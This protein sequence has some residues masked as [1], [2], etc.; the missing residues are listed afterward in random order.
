MSCWRGLLPGVI[1]TLRYV[2]E[3]PLKPSEQTI[4]L[5]HGL[6]NKPFVMNGI[7]KCFGKRGIRL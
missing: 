6:L 4:V 1:W 7:A 2:S 3:R 5:V